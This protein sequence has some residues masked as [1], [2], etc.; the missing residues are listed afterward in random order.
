MINIATKNCPYNGDAL[1]G[2][3]SYFRNET[4]EQD[5]S[6]IGLISLDASGNKAS[7]DLVFFDY[8]NVTS[9]AWSTA[10]EDGWIE[11]NFMKNRLAIILDTLFVATLGSF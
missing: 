11:F 9:G 7:A 2:L 5:P 4:K 8:G 10:D 1:D 6:K 3:V